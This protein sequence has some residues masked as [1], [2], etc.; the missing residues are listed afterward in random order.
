LFTAATLLGSANLN[1]TVC[2]VM[3]FLLSYLHYVLYT[4]N[5]SSLVDSTNECKKT[6][7]HR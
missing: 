2:N 1:V 4:K 5:F 3:S 7:L 6:Y